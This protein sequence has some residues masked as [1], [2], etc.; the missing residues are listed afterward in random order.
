[1]GGTIL[2]EVG[3]RQS[4]TRFNE[5][6]G[7]TRLQAAVALRTYGDE[8]EKIQPGL[9]AA[10]GSLGEKEFAAEQAQLRKAMAKP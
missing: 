8:A 7:N 1:M 3:Q 5:T 2:G 9:T 6:A 10:L 4:D